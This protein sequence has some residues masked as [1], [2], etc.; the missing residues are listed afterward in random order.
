[1]QSNDWREWELF[2]WYKAE[3]LQLIKYLDDI[4]TRQIEYFISEDFIEKVDNKNYK[5]VKKININNFI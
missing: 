5:L 3:Y 2:L 4:T 1:M